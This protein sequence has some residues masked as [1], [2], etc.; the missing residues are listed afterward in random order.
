MAIAFAFISIYGVYVFGDVG[1]FSQSEENVSLCNVQGYVFDEYGGAVANA[2]SVNC[3]I[4]RNNNFN[5]TY[6]TETGAGF[7]PNFNHSYR[8]TMVCSNVLSDSLNIL[9]FNNTGNGTSTVTMNSATTNL[10]ITFTDFEVPLITGITGNISANVGETITIEVNATDN[11]G[12]IG[13]NITLGNGSVIALV[14]D[15]GNTYNASIEISL[16]NTLTIN[17][18]AAVYD[19]ANNNKTDGTYYITITDNISPTAN[20][21]VN[22]TS[23]DQ[24]VNIQFNA[25][26]STD[27]VGI[28]AYY[29]DF[30][31]DSTIN[32]SAEPLHQFSGEG[33]YTVQLTVSDAAGNNNTDTV[34]VNVRDSIAPFVIINSPANGT[35]NI[36]LK[37]EVNLSFNEF[38]L[39]STLNQNSVDIRDV[40]GNKVY[41]NV[42]FDTTLNKTI[43]D[44][45][46]LLK[47]NTLYIVNVTTAVLDNSTNPVATSHI[48]NFTTKLRDTDND[49]IPDNEEVD[50][51]ND[52]IVDASDKLLGDATDIKAELST[53]NVSVGGSYDLAQEFSSTSN[54]KIENGSSPL[55]SFSMD[56]SSASLDLTN[57]SI[58]ESENQSVGEIMVHGLDLSGGTKTIYLENKSSFRGVCVKDIEV[59][60]ITE[61]TQAC[62]GTGET[63][64]ACNGT[65]QSSYTCVYN[66]TTNRFEISGL[67]YSGV[68]EIDYNPAQ[69]DPAEEEDEDDEEDDSEDS[70]SETSSAG[71]GGGG[72]GD[73]SDCYSQWICGSWGEC[74]ATGKKIRQCYDANECKEQTGNPLTTLS[75]VY[76][77][78]YTGSSEEDDNDNEE[79][80][81]SIDDNLYQESEEDQIA[82]KLLG[83]GTTEEKKKLAGIKLLTGRAFSV[84]TKGESDA[85]FVLLIIVMILSV[86][87]YH[88]IRDKKTLKKAKDQENQE[89]YN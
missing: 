17:Y 47:E 89:R 15:A 67:S 31:D 6:T 45:Y 62:T 57:I 20:A 28:T 26:T 24:N 84:V 41:G 27:N 83:K 56:F 33:T 80:L 73:S 86:L 50:D 53:I 85:Y 3:S 88:I 2:T 21:N 58:Y 30:N 44:P 75:C 37:T 71:G 48:F 78:P 51:D 74:M 4:F 54:V 18:T 49:G 11:V 9:G 82:K 68:R 46:V 61:I 40:N 59:N 76:I 14:A 63:K 25:S 39:L 10:N 34:T 60:S 66:S 23:V 64:V 19:N 38:I 36:S 29:W 43:F 79:S 52:G 35:I 1:V 55:I 5:S 70:S 8:C 87:G 81:I 77:P 16:N 69:N 32:T 65:T 22:Q 72:G 12:I 42:S 13:G 7:P